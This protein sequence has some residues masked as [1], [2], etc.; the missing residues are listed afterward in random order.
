MAAF[1]KPGFSEADIDMCMFN[2]RRPD[3]GQFVRKRSTVK[4]TKEIV[5]FLARKCN[6][7]HEHSHIHGWLKGSRQSVS[8]WAGGY[9]KE[10]AEAILKGA[11]LALKKRGKAT[12]RGR[13]R[14]REKDLKVIRT[15]EDNSRR[16]RTEHLLVDSYPVGETRE[17]TFMP[18]DEEK[19]AAPRRS[20]VLKRK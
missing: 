12:S 13:E 16:N 11:T 18:A 19:F 2:L 20:Q 6:K 17:E 1:D 9:T 7:K 3:N 8:E 10:F 14:E 15:R 5:E 4:G